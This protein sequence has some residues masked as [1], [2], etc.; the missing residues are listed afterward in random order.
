MLRV[1][2][3]NLDLKKEIP[4]GGYDGTPV[5]ETHTTYYTT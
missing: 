4:L 1:D 3:M 2:S 5:W